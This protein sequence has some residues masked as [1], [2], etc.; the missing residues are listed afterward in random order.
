[1]SGTSGVVSDCEG[2]PK[3][4]T[5]TEALRRSKE[6]GEYYSRPNCSSWLKYDPNWLYTLTAEDLIANDWFVDA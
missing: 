1:M 5:I 4:L 2:E 6:T 3:G